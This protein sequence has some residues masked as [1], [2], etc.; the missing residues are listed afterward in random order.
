MAKRNKKSWVAVLAIFTAIV[1][2]AVAVA[3]FL[4]KKTK[5]F[6]EEMDYDGS[7]YYEDDD[8]LD[9]DEYEDSACCHTHEDTD[10]KASTLDEDDDSSDETV[11]PTSK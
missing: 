4:K 8:Y 1:G 11:P 6:G 2:A 7:I 5:K 9:E 10:D 3:M